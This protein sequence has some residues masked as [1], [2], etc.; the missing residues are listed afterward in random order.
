[1]HTSNTDQE[2]KD[3]S[4]EWLSK[5]L[6]A[7]A[8]G[9]RS[10]THDQLDGTSFIKDELDQIDKV[11]AE[12]EQA[13]RSHLLADVM[14]VKPSGHEVD[15]IGNPD[16]RFCKGYNQALEEWEQAFNELLGGDK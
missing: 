13:I 8:E 7:L 4:M 11:K 14:R 15:P 16:Y 10:W 2:S 6:E 5:E 12:T 1:M 9:W 3:N